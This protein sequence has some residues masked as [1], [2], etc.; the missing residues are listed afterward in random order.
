MCPQ[1]RKALPELCKPGLGC[2]RHVG[3]HS[4]RE[5]VVKNERMGWG[6]AKT[7]HH[8]DHGTRECLYIDRQPIEGETRDSVSR[9]AVTA[10]I[11][12]RVFG[13]AA[14]SSVRHAPSGFACLI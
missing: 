1:Y 12:W 6:L 13:V 9:A 10:H 2:Q 11:I 14:R 8:G 7:L 4:Q 3:R 5:S